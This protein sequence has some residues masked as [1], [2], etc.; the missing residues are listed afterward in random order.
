VFANSAAIFSLLLLVTGAVKVGRPRDVAR[1]IGEMGLPIAWWSG[2]GIGVVEIAVGVAAL[3]HPNGLLAQGATYAI[4]A[5]WVAAALRR[6]APLA[7]CGCLG[8]E[9]TPPSAG[10]LALNIVAVVVS[11]AAVTS[12]PVVLIPGLGGVAQVAV[13]VVG[14]FISYIVLTDGAR[15]TGVRGR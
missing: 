3:L 8:R 1:A 2:I 15:L 10:H 11:F 9:D 6:D 12:G 14:L 4:F 7:S 5:G 13:V